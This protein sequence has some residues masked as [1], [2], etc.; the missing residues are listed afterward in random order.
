MPSSCAIVLLLFAAYTPRITS[1]SRWGEIVAVCGGREV[2]HPRRRRHGGTLQKT[3]GGIGNAAE[4]HAVVPVIHR[5]EEE[6]V[7]SRDTAKCH[8]VH[9]SAESA[10]KKARVLPV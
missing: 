5:G 8:T 9:A 7:L 10:A 3:H 2:D 1:H 4:R 6:R